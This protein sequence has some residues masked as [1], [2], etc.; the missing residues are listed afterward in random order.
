MPFSEF[1]LAMGKNL[2]KLAKKDPP[3]PTRGPSRLAVPKPDRSDWQSSGQKAVLEAMT[4]EL[5][6]TRAA[7]NWVL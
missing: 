5:E 2:K 6:N 4:A 3:Q 7:W 1:A